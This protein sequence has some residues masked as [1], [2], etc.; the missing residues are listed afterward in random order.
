ML[1]RSY[2][3]K[4][5]KF[6]EDPKASIMK[7]ISKFTVTSKRI[8]WRDVVTLSYYVKSFLVTMFVFSVAVRNKV[9][10]LYC[11]GKINIKN[12]TYKLINDTF[13]F[14]NVDLSLF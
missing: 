2:E 3:G 9:K 5:P 13:F 6:V 8:M 1:M 7:S 12:K 4:W 14:R 11:I 10:P